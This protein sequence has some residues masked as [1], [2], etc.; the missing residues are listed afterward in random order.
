[1]LGEFL[2]HQHCVQMARPWPPTL[3]EWLIPRK[4]CQANPCQPLMGYGSSRSSTSARQRGQLTLLR[5]SARPL[6]VPLVLGS[7]KS[8]SSSTVNV[9]WNDRELYYCRR[10]SCCSRTRRVDEGRRRWPHDVEPI[11]KGRPAGGYIGQSGP[12]EAARLKAVPKLW[13]RASTRNGATVV[14]GSSQPTRPPE[15]K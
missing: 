11:G 2:Q 12:V 9:C 4:P 13:S 15:L 8:K 3:R 5:I 10:E 6:N 14:R 7:W 1:M